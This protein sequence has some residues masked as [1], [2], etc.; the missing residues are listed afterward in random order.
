LD[1]NIEI[2]ANF[3][4]RNQKVKIKSQNILL[5]IANTH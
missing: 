3:Y 2:T 4:I 5:D 1:Q